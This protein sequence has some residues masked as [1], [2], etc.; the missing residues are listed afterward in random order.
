V[1]AKYVEILA[2]TGSLDYGGLQRE[3]IALLR[4]DEDLRRAYAEQFRYILVDEYQDTNVAQDVLLE[5]LAGER[6]NVFCV[7]DEDQSIYGFRG[8][9]IENALRFEERWPG[10]T[11]YDLPTNYRSAPPIVELAK[12]V[13]RFNVDTHRD[14][15]LEAVGERAATLSGRTFRHAAEEADWIA[16]EIAALRL[17]GVELG[18]IAVL[19]RSLKEIGPRLAYALRRH[20]IAFHA[21]L[22]GPLHPTAAALLSLLEL[23][24]P[25]R[26]DELQTEQA[27]DVLASPL[28]GADPLDLRRFRRAA[29]TPY[30]ALRDSGEFDP[31][32]EALAIVKRQQSAG[33]AIYVL[34]ERLGYFRELQSRVRDDSHQE[35]VEELAAITI[36]SDAANGFEGELAAFPASYRAGELAAEDGLPPQALPS[37]AVALLTVHQAKGLEWDAVFVCELVEGRFP[38]LT[39]SRYE[40][41]DRDDFA[42]RTLDEA[43]RA[44]RALEEER[45]L[46]YVAA[47]RARSRLYLTATEEAREEA[48][49]ALSRF[50]TEAEGHLDAATDGR[51]EFASADEALAALR[52]AG[53]GP[54]GWRTNPVTVNES[55]MLPRGGLYTSASGLDPYDNCPL[56]FF[57]G[58]MLELVRP[59]GSALVFGGTVHDVLEAFHDPDGPTDRS[60]ERLRALADRKWRRGITPAPLEHEYRRKLDW[61]LGEYHRCEIVEGPA[62][63]VLAVERYFRFPLDASTISGRIDR[64]D[65]LTDGLLRLTDYKSGKA[66][67]ARAAAEDLQ[68]ALYALACVEQPELAALGEVGEIEYLFPAELA[69]GRLKRRSQAVTPELADATRERVRNVIGKIAAEQFDFSPEADC[70]FCDFQPICPRHH[71]RD[72]PV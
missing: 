51:V 64:I 20:G 29:R 4:S 48:G 8:A 40:L 38:S 39:R 57:Y 1:R 25:E 46:F 14:K 34:W 49:R 47:T 58:T 13:I 42:R 72:V 37:D 15:P 3:T 30:G 24:G 26:W 59:Q 28:F 54:P 55:P 6:R 44:R 9:E 43:E 60:L 7:A 11:V 50:Y 12:H 62:P 56:Q 10:A 35:D 63:D 61:M 41:F 66:M 68:L 67:T 71:G 53:G 18:Q 36:L 19:A 2:E 69:Y 23:A 5:L 16:R 70:M 17:E 33:T 27:L 21:P 22:A 52:R 31:F 45:R 65:R 32:F